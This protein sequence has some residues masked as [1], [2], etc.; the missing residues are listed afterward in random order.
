MKFLFLSLHATHLIYILNYQEALCLLLLISFPN[1]LQNEFLLTTRTFVY[2][3]LPHIKDTAEPS[4]YL[5]VLQL[6]AIC[7]LHLLL[8]KHTL[9]HVASWLFD[10]SASFPMSLIFH[11]FILLTLFVIRTL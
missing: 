11:S 8:T 3:K 5:F 7:Y 4:G 1:E 10:A 9:C 2:L 6:I